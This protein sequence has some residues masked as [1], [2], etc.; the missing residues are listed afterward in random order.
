M[1]PLSRLV[2]KASILVTLLLSTWVVNSPTL[3]YGF[4]YDDI[5][6]I[7]ERAP[8]W[9]EGWSG[10]RQT[11]HWGTG[12]H[13]VLLSFDADR[14]QP[15]SPSP[16][17]RTNLALAAA[18]VVLAYLLA[19]ALG[20]GVQGAFTSALLFSLH[21]IHTD[22][23]VSIVGRAELLAALGL[24]GALTLHL[25][26]YPGGWPSMAAAAVLFLIGLSSKESTVVLLPLIALADFLGLA[27][28][29]RER[30]L[31]SY[32][33]YLATLAAWVAFVFPHFSTLDTIS[34]VDNPLAHAPWLQRV[35]KASAILWHYA[36]LVVWPLRLLPE[37]SFATTDPSLGAGSV[38]VAA[39]L[40]LSLG[41]WQ[42]RQRNPRLVFCLMWFP[43]AFAVTA[44][45]VFPIGTVMAERL[46]YLPSLG[47]L[48]IA[49]L[50][51][52]A[53][54]ARGRSLRLAS[55]AMVAV[56]ALL[57]AFAYDA[58]ARYWSSNDY[59]HVQA[60]VASPR[61]AKAHHNLGLLRARQGRLDEAAASFRRALRIY[62]AFGA[63]TYYLA[64]V[65]TKL[66]RRQQAAE[67]YRSYLAI[68]PDDKGAYTQLLD[69]EMQLHD[70]TAA[71][72]TTRRLIELEPGNMG[73]ITTLTQLER[74]TH[75]ES[76]SP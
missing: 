14:R 3:D 57:L 63:A 27:E 2:A 28:H 35:S 10:L 43:L 73:Y 37:R 68:V 42:L 30:R 18:V 44:N 67:V 41:C 9:E 4:V 1:G 32:A 70:Y 47:P 13:A 58:R 31:K 45:I 15:L 12:R 7:V 24:M 11:R 50:A 76:L 21:P 26:G 54:A 17:H 64:G 51:I 23:V 53:V 56:A 72:A 34:Y 20:L 66:E 8:I 65:L 61:S 19:R 5:A 38:A 36:A 55:V 60:A 59:Y 62:P 33:V 25:R 40:G 69:L 74:K 75:G 52:D 49:G 39:W 6:V 22:A 48:L 46:A 16:F 71:L 29:T